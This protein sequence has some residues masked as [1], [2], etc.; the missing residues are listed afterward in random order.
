LHKQDYLPSP[1]DVPAIQGVDATD[2]EKPIE[3]RSS[4]DEPFAALAFKIM[5][6]P[7]VGTSPAHA[8]FIDVNFAEWVQT[9]IS[10]FRPY[11]KLPV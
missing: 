3:R 8:N 5:N 7:F 4:D 9:V 10:S 2:L 11:A 1:L 6:D